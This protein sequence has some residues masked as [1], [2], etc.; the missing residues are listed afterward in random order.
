MLEPDCPDYWCNLQ[1]AVRWEGPAEYGQ[2]LTA[3][4]EKYALFESQ[5][6]DMGVADGEL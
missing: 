6:D 1:V 4:G 3:G 2:M 5:D